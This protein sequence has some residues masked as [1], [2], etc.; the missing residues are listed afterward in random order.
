[1]KFQMFS[2]QEYNE[3]RSVE[4][5]SEG[6]GNRKGIPYMDINWIDV[7]KC[8]IIS[9]IRTENKNR[10]GRWQVARWD[11]KLLKNIKVMLKVLCINNLK[12]VHNCKCNEQPSITH[13]LFGCV[14]VFIT[15]SRGQMWS[16]V[17]NTMHQAMIASVD[18]MS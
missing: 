13:I 7:S 4:T 15:N 14:S 11:C 12:C 16:T 1:M 6:K 17:E 8:K 9:V 2:I 10:M 3:N 5:E 18:S